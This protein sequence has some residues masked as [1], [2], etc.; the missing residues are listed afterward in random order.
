MSHH[1]SG[2]D[3]GFPHGDPR[4]DLTDVYAFPKPDG[5]DKSILIMNVHPSAVVSPPG[6]TTREPF[7]PEA[8]Y[9][10]KIDTN[11]DAVAD[12]AYRV[13]VS[14]SEDGSQTA[15]LRRVEGAEAAGTGDGGQ[16]I[17]D[18]APVSTDR[19]ARVAEAG[20]YRVFAGWRRD[21]F[22]FDTRGALNDLRFTGDDFFIDKDVCSIVLEVPNSALGSRPVGLWGRTLRGAGRVWV[23]VERGALPAQA[24]FL[25]GAEREAYHAGEPANDARFI[26]V[27]AHALEHAGGYAPEEAR[28]VAGTLLPDMLPYDATRPASFPGNGR[29]LTDDA[30][31]VFL[32]VLTN[33]RVTGDKV[34]PHVDL[35]AGFPYLGPPHNASVPLFM[36]EDVMNRLE[37]VLYTAKVHTTGGR[38]GLSRSSDGRLEVKLSR[39]GSPGTGTNPEQLFA[40]GWSACFESAM[41][42]AAGKMKITLPADRAVEAEVDLGPEGGAFSLAARLC[43]SLPGMERATAQ[44][45][46]EA[47]HQVCPY[48][49][50]T[51]GNIA[52]QT[53]LV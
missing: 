38:A 18:A 20:G 53:T 42:F 6:P 2:P 22:F 4:L 11:G 12:I 10:L 29:T 5:A 16:I 13:R 39:P 37:K 27:F 21:P 7:S 15:T 33:G 23:Q 14:S 9:E 40:A 35:L 26:A 30:A 31:D 48:S 3:F 47:A 52:V 49:R 41:E 19:D 50:A 34:G 51:H 44:R 36:K 8:L 46:V 1:Y 28:R 25:V 17:I 45:L 24:V 32:A 43:V